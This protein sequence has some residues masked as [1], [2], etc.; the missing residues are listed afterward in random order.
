MSLD[1]DVAFSVITVP[2]CVTLSSNLVSLACELVLVK[3][4]T[5]GSAKKVM[6]NSCFTSCKWIAAIKQL[7]L[8]LLFHFNTI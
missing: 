8:K 7:I 3:S 4:F 5:S 1:W 6:K 2:N